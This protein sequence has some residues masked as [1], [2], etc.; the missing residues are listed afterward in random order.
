MPTYTYLSC[1]IRDCE[2][3]AHTDRSDC[4]YT[5]S[6]VID[7][8]VGSNW[9]IY[10]DMNKEPLKSRGRYRQYVND[11]RKPFCKKVDCGPGGLMMFNGIDHIHFREKLD[12]DT[13]KK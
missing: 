13:Y 10:V 7:K 5:V 8:P 2:L 9:D 6:Y 12:A 11:E 3:P 4:E 1:Y